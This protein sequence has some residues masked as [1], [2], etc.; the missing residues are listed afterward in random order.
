[1]LKKILIVLVVLVAGVLIFASTRPDHYH[2][3]RS[4]T[5]AAPPA[6]IFAQL[7]DFKKWPAWSPWEKRDPQ[8]KKSF[9][10][11]PTGVG[12][13]YSWQGNKEVGK[14]KMT[15][16]HSEP[17]QHIRLRLEFMEPFA[18]VATSG[19]ELS[20]QGGNTVVTWGMD[21]TN[22][23]ISKIFSLAMDMD[24][25]I[26]G[27]FESGLASLKGLSEA[28]AARRAQAESQANAAALAARQAAGAAAAPPVAAAPAAGKSGA[29][30]PAKP[31]R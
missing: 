18:A 26:G 30:R 23:L 1:M 28:E 7:E 12:S 2:V 16:I 20:P 9:E 27:D 3:D 24:K 21:G 22:N 4:V 13:S 29:Q 31:Q 5:I 19:F 10:G 25:M 14:G 8:M 6:V 17:P 15:I 11:P